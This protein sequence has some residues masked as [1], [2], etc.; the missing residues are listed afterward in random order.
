MASKSSR[1]DPRYDDTYISKEAY[2]DPR[3]PPASDAYEYI[4]P[5]AFPEPPTHTFDPDTVP[6]PRRGSPSRRHKSNRSATQPPKTSRRS[7]PAS[8]RAVSPAPRSSRLDGSPPPPRHSRRTR[9]PPRGRPAR[10]ATAPVQ[11]TKTSRRSKFVDK[12]AVQ[13]LNKYGRKGLHTLGDV[14]EAYAAAQ[15]GADVRGRSVDRD[16][17]AGGFYSKPRGSSHNYFLD[18]DMRPHRRSH[19]LSPSPSPSPVR[20]GTARH[21]K[22]RRPSLNGRQK[23]YSVSPGRYSRDS[24]YDRGRGQSHRHSRRRSPSSSLTPSPRPRGR[25]PRSQPHGDSTTT[26]PTSRRHSSMNAYRSN[27]KTPHPEG[28]HRW[29]LAA[30]AALEAGGVT[31]FRLRKEPGPWTGEKGAKV[32]TAAVGAAAIDA[33]IDKDPRRRG[34]GGMKGMAEN[35]I[36]GML[37][38]KLMGFKS[39]TTRKGD[40]RYV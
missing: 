25:R 30:R 5:D 24:S 16:Y 22:R 33:F 11:T 34:G 2:P 29:Q 4:G 23:S 15:A 19:H 31:A 10:A 18:N 21:S 27:M 36:G 6:P 26:G 9:S 13:N 14:V 1:Y 17:P 7:P 39:A 3:A 20:R 8:R 28:A 12:P 37:A 32:V 40:S 35:A 38:S